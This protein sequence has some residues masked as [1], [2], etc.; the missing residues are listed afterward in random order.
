MQWS[1]PPRHHVTGPST[2]NHNPEALIADM[3]KTCPALCASIRHDF[4]LNVIFHPALIA[5]HGETF[6]RLAA[7]QIAMQNQAAEMTFI[8]NAL[9][10]KQELLDV[11]TSSVK[12]LQ[13]KLVTQQSELKDIRRLLE[14][15]SQFLTNPDPVNNGQVPQCCSQESDFA[16]QGVIVS[17]TTPKSALTEIDSAVHKF[18]SRSAALPPL[19]LSHDSDIVDKYDERHGHGHAETRGP[20]FEFDRI[21]DCTPGHQSEQIFD[22]PSP[23]PPSVS[24]AAVFELDASSTT[25]VVSIATKRHK[26]NAEDDGEHSERV[27]TVAKHQ[28]PTV[29]KGTKHADI[30]IMKREDDTESALHHFHKSLETPKIEAPDEESH[31]SPATPLDI[32]SNNTMHEKRPTA[33]T[34]KPVSYAAAVCTTPVTPP[35]DN[36][37]NIPR[38]SPTLD[39]SL[40]P[41]LGFTLEPLPKPTTQQVQAQQQQPECL[42]TDSHSE[43]AAFDFEEWKQRKMAAGTWR[44]RHN[45]ST[46]PHSHGRPYHPIYRGRGGRFHQNNENLRPGPVDEE[47]RKQQWLAWKRNLIR[48]GRWNQTH[49]FREAWKNE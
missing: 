30:K 48:Q 39:S 5:L 2:S 21:E 36:I 7:S 24:T 13:A 19:E 15:Q 43:D 25:P 45:R 42:D 14:Q 3:W 1:F 34:N 44:D 38:S 20:T 40:A 27:E 23:I 28:T 10:Q 41:D 18:Y 29:G 11:N 8:R 16:A 6:L 47:A 46:I 12:D 17:P 4:D 9:S 32:G 35:K 33:S 49:P 22:R 31:M 26:S 37:L